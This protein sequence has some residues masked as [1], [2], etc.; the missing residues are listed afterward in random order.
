MILGQRPVRV[1]KQASL[2]LAM[3]AIA[4]KVLIPAGYML[5]AQ[6]GPGG[7]PTM[8]I[9]TGHGEF[10]VAV[11]ANGKPSAPDP[12]KPGDGK[13]KAGDHPCTF[14]SASVAHAAPAAFAI[15]A[16]I[17]LAW[18]PPPPRLTTQRPGLGLAAP[19]PYTTGPPSI[20]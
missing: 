20:I 3:L 8:V 17:R 10:V 4:V 5:S 18:L 14:A 7:S 13:S 2:L 16:P 19:P 6:V 1:L 15:V 11:D 12:S 9:C